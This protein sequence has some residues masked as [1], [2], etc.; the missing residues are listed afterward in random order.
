M[1]PFKPFK[2]FKFSKKPDGNKPDGS[3]SSE[4]LP[5]TPQNEVNCDGKGATAANT[6]HGDLAAGVS[7]P[8]SRSSLR[9]AVDSITPANSST[10]MVITTV[11]GGYSTVADTA[12]T[13]YGHLQT[14]ENVVGKVSTGLTQISGSNIDILQTMHDGVTTLAAHSPAVDHLLA[15][16]SSIM[17]VG[18]TVPF[19]APIFT[20]LDYLVKMEQQVHQ[21]D[22]KCE[23][24]VE[25]VAFLADLVVNLATVQ[26]AAQVETVAARIETTLKD[27]VVLIKA[28][29]AQGSIVRRINIGNAAKFS[30]LAL[31]IKDRTTDL[32]TVLSV[33]QYIRDKLNNT[34]IPVDDQDAKARRFLE[35]P[36]RRQIAPGYQSSEELQSF[37]AAIGEAITDANLKGLHT[38]LDDL[39]ESSRKQ[40]EDLKVSIAE[41]IE[42]ALLAKDRLEVQ[43]EKAPILDCVQCGNTY[44]EWMQEDV[45]TD[46]L[47]ESGHCRFH[48]LPGG[49]CCGGKPCH[50][51]RHSKTHHQRFPY[52]AH[53]L[54]AQTLFATHKKHLVTLLMA[55]M[56]PGF[57]DEERSDSN[58]PDVADELFDALHEVL[59]NIALMPNEPAAG[60]DAKY[61]L[62]VA[63]DIQ[64]DSE[65][66]APEKPYIFRFYTPDELA[67][68]LVS[69][70]ITDAKTHRRVRILEIG[71]CKL[72]IREGPIVGSN[73]RRTFQLDSFL[74][75]FWAPRPLHSHFILDYLTLEC[76]ESSE[77]ERYAFAQ[78]EDMGEEDIYEAYPKSIV[79]LEQHRT[80]AYAEEFKLPM[81]PAIK[82]RYVRHPSNLTETSRRHPHNGIHVT[83]E[84]DAPDWYVAEPRTPSSP[85]H[86]IA[87][88]VTKVSGRHVRLDGN[89][90]LFISDGQHYEKE[91]L[92]VRFALADDGSDVLE[93]TGNLWYHEL[94]YPQGSQAGQTTLEALLEP[95]TENNGNNPFPRTRVLF[96]AQGYTLTLRDLGVAPP[97]SDGGVDKNAESLFRYEVEVAATIPWM[98]GRWRRSLMYDISLRL[99]GTVVVLEDPTE[100]L[101]STDLVPSVLLSSNDE[102]VGAVDTGGYRMQVTESQ[103]VTARPPSPIVSTPLH[104]H[105]EYVTAVRA[106]VKR[107]SNSQIQT[108][109]VH[110]DTVEI[111]T[112]TAIVAA[113]DKASSNS[114]CETLRA[115]IDV[116]EQCL[117]QERGLVSLNAVVREGLPKQDAGAAE[118]VAS[119]GRLLELQEKGMQELMKLSEQVLVMERA[120]R[121]VA[122]AA[123]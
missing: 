54:W 35:Q 89:D 98:D 42:T 33:E 68:D 24:L 46:G 96:D 115:R 70:D 17:R 8:P 31:A 44:Q 84:V 4:P 81:Y 12:S 114:C 16:V 64:T 26:L 52:A 25:R 112:A 37:A 88:G 30:D 100:R 48:V 53:R 86:R 95:L 85:P 43:R 116:L 102:K 38:S 67:D 1:A 47:T 121:G 94:L 110:Y 99:Q 118:L 50:R 117:A 120:G 82:G 90:S 87:V 71:V 11:I 101:P 5:P 20:T 61:R 62:A 29:R 60:I 97:P 36:G 41:S 113:A 74:T 57:D 10:E 91:S 22:A 51:A 28:Y 66:S 18:S 3:S 58:L 69:S 7:R 123:E 79:E 2:L 40:L 73:G 15:A 77:A 63:M 14:A 78:I 34:H 23:D 13:Y 39:I 49:K 19:I 56:T 59:I 45:L 92:L 108:S 80:R 109:T 55:P 107:E 75:P 76:I 72:V 6:T 32:T 105:Q 83:F 27:C 65:R 103:L 111:R 106:V 119:V 122:P 104:T 21:T 9:I 93:P